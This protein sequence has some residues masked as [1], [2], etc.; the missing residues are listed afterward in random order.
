MYSV[1][2]LTAIDDTVKLADTSTDE[3]FYLFS[4]EKLLPV[5]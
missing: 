1:G 4:E 3:K 5:K 2:G